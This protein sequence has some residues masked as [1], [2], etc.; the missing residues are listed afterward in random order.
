MP[1]HGTCLCGGITFQVDENPLV[2]SCCHCLNCKKYTGT[3]FTTN[4][5]FPT[6]S[7]TMTKGKELL[8]SFRDGAQ[9][10]GNALQRNF[11]SQCGSPLYNDGG[12]SGKTLAVFYSAL[13][14]FGTEDEKDR[15]PEVEYYTKDRAA[16]VHPVEGAEQ[17]RTKPGREI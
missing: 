3:V 7:L 17:A 13:T 12:D 10:S 1:F 5:V 15:K 9:D 14:D 16:W 11:C 6:G 2:I 4:V 8:S